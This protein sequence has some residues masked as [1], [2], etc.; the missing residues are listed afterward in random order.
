ME[1]AL[2]TREPSR[3]QSFFVQST[4]IGITNKLRPKSLKYPV[5]VFFNFG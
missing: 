4:P 5:F 1:D 3:P 2:D